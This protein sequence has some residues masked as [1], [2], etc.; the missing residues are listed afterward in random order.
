MVGGLKLLFEQIYGT[1]SGF[2]ISRVCCSISLR[3]N[4]TL[5]AH[6]QTCEQLMPVVSADSCSL[7]NRKQNLWFFE[8]RWLSA[9]RHMHMLLFSYWVFPMCLVTINVCCDCCQL[10]QASI[11]SMSSIHVLYI[12]VVVKQTIAPSESHFSIDST[13][14]SENEI[15]IHVVSTPLYFHAP[16]SL[17]RTSLSSARWSK[18]VTKATFWH[19]DV[20]TLL[21][22]KL[23]VR[24][25]KQ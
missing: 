20:G 6:H 8:H 16:M 10:L 1:F 9:C 24:T 21:Q 4:R 19:I 22:T 14:S 17:E 18:W 3:T 15:Q 7:C 13:S 23:E 11:S 25:L 12:H 5:W 2:A